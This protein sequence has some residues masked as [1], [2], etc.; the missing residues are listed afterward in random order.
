MPSAN[1]IIYIG[2]YTAYQRQ[3]DDIIFVKEDSKTF[4]V[5]GRE[6]TFTREDNW[7]ELQNNADKPFFENDPNNFSVSWQY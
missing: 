5:N 2:D 4:T 3:G 6:Y 1:Y 7:L